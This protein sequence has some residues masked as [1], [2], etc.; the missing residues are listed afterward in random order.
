[1]N[2]AM[3][4]SMPRVTAPRVGSRTKIFTPYGTN[5]DIGLFP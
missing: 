3:S 1:M 5:G 2:T 4:A